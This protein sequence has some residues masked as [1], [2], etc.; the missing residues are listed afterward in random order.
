MSIKN[1][2]FF[3]RMNIHYLQH[4]PSRGPG[5]ITAWAVARGCRVR[6]VLLYDG[7][8][9][10]DPS[11]VD[12]LVVLG[13]PMNAYDD[14]YP[15]LAE[16]KEFLRRCIKRKKKILGMGLGAQLIAEVLGA[17]I[18]PNQP[19]KI[20]WYIISWTSYALTNPLFNFVPCHQIT[21][22]FNK[23]TFTLP[24]GAIRLASSRFCKNQAFVWRKHVVGIQFHLEMV[25]EDLEKLVAS[26]R[27]ELKERGRNIQSAEHILSRPNYIKDNNYTMIRFLDRFFLQRF[28]APAEVADAV[29]NY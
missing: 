1:F 14:S 9:L 19:K 4:D 2:E 5:V 26:L 29:L 6:P 11:S 17:K 12:A 22:H 15:W 18:H 20:G 13:G 16:E 23:D 3:R 27:E 25:H 8:T 24:P 21:L 28:Y 10:P 7:G